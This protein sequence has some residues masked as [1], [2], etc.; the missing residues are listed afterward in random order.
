M[1]LYRR[2]M[3]LCLASTRS[4]N[5]AGVGEVTPDP[6][7]GR[8]DRDQSGRPTGVLREQAMDLI[9]RICPPPTEEECFE[10]MTEA[11]PV[12][13]SLGLTGIQDQRIWKGYD[14][15][16]AFRAW[17]RLWREGRLSLR[18]WMNLAGDY[19]E[20]AVTLGLR[21]G[22]GNDYLRVGHLKFFS[23]GSMGS[24]TAWVLDPFTCGGHGIAVC[25]LD[26]LAE[27]IGKA[28][29]NGLATAVHAIGD[30]AVRKLVDIH[31]DLAASRKNE[32]RQTPLPWAPHR[33]EHAQMMRPEDIKRLAGLNVFA[34]VQPLHITDDISIHD[35]YLGDLSRF[36]YPFKEMLEAGV[37]VTSGSDC[38]VSDPNPLWGIHAAVTRQR[39]DNTPEGAWYPAQRLTVEEAVLSYTMGPALVSGREAELGSL[40]QGKLG[41][42]VVLDRN[43]YEI[44]PSEIHLARPVLTVVGGKVVYRA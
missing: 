20:E 7:G 24:T 32:R 8:I 1:L 36:V 17:Q 41:D 10:A 35:R 25:S 5:L 22:F 44:D 30:R 14:A 23:D 38:P 18:C 21:T 19:L 3:H 39:R 12:L 40:S 9:S 28:D 13:G 29:R 16:P 26:E 6:E 11:L 27:S 4:L 43:I 15:Q 34:S 31:A 33:I 2:D 42:L 37:R